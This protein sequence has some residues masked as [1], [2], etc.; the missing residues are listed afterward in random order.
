[1]HSYYLKVFHQNYRFYTPCCKISGRRGRWSLPYFNFMLLRW[2]LR[3]QASCCLIFFLEFLNIDHL[4]HLCFHSAFRK[5]L[6]NGNY[7]VF[8]YSEKKLKPCTKTFVFEIIYHRNR[9]L[10]LKKALQ[11]RQKKLLLKEQYRFKTL[12]NYPP[13]PLPLNARPSGPPMIYILCISLIF[14]P[15]LKYVT[16]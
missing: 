15:F 16:L 5:C 2:P 13:P 14:P 4:M 9:D 8:C 12:E 3:P 11:Y 6:E 1:M 7:K 10:Y